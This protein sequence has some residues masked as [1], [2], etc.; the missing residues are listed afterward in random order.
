MTDELLLQLKL[1]V[2]ERGLRNAILSFHDALASHRQ[3]L[4]AIR[5]GAWE[6]LEKI[7]VAATFAAPESLLQTI[8]QARSELGSAEGWAELP[9]GR[10]GIQSI[11]D[12]AIRLSALLREER[13]QTSFSSTNGGSR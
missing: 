8:R 10:E 7:H 5:P 11:Y 12:A 6:V 9:R 4:F 1:V 3:T 13:E 2:A